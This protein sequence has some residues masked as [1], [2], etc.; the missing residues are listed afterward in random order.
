MKAKDLIALRLRCLLN[1]D[2]TFDQTVQDFYQDLKHSKVFNWNSFM[3]GFIVGGM[4]ALAIL[5]YLITK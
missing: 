2:F 3:F 4:L 5:N 1:G